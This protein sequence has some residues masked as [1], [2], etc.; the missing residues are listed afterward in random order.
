MVNILVIESGEEDGLVG[1]IVAFLS[2]RVQ[3]RIMI[4]HFVLMR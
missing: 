3:C 4:Y 1:E 2:S